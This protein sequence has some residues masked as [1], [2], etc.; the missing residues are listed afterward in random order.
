[1]V[2]NILD[3]H[4]HYRWWQLAGPR[5]VLNQTVLLISVCVVRLSTGSVNPLPSD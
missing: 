4:Y 3:V 1:M 5:W 2:C